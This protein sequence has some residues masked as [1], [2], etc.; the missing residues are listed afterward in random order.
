MKS[1]FLEKKISHTEFEKSLQSWNKKLKSE[2]FY[3]A[4]L[5]VHNGH[6]IDSMHKVNSR[7]IRTLDFSRKTTNAVL[8]HLQI[9]DVFK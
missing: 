9:V 4:L 8:S 2:N 7:G 5:R 6:F 3:K 1:L